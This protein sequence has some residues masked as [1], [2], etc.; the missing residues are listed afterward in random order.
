MDQAETGAQEVSGAGHGEGGVRVTVGMPDVQRHAMGADELADRRDRLKHGIGE[1]GFK[2]GVGKPQYAVESEYS[3]LES[4]T[5]S[6]P[7]QLQV[8]ALQFRFWKPLRF[9]INIVTIWR[10][11]LA[12]GSPNLIEI[13]KNSHLLTVAALLGARNCGGQ[14]RGWR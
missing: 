11:E 8:H 7:R 12:I 14:V 1:V 2:G 6:Y 9:G 3:D 5:Y 13:D 4:T 10:R